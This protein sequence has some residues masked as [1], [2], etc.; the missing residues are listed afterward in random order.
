[1]DLNVCAMAG[2]K[3]AYR[4]G[5]VPCEVMWRAS[6]RGG[7]GAVE[8]GDHRLDRPGRHPHREQCAPGGT[9]MCFADEPTERVSSRQSSR[10]GAGAA[11]MDK[12]EF[13]RAV[14]RLTGDEDTAGGQ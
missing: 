10:G 5:V 3:P 6:G 14:E 2:D 4:V 11:P 8:G 9:L 13:D 7:Q 12:G 1:M